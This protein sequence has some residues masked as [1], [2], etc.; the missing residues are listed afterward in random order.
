MA[1]LKTSNLAPPVEEKR[2]HIYNDHKGGWREEDRTA[3]GAA[4]V[5]GIPNSFKRNADSAAFNEGG[6]GGGEVEW[7]LPDT[8]RIHGLDVVRY[9]QL[10]RRAVSPI[11]LS[12][13]FGQHFTRTI[14]ISVGVCFKRTLLEPYSYLYC[15]ICTIP[16]VLSH[17]YCFILLIPIL[18]QVQ[19]FNPI[20][21]LWGKVLK[22]GH[23]MHHSWRHITTKESLNCVPV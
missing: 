23:M 10:L 6:E 1:P 21:L 17:L 18:L 14:A 19:C 13:L 8:P 12:V 20:T 7:A 5:T 11:L 4:R 16:S 3:K 15:P 22:F 9:D 2:K